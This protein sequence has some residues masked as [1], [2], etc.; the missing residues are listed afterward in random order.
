[1]LAAFHFIC[2]EGRQD[3]CASVTMLGAALRIPAEALPLFA[4]K[5]VR[6]FGHDDSAKL[7]AGARAVERWNAQLTS[8]GA[9]VDAFSFAGLQKPD[10]TPAKDLND[11]IEACAGAFEPGGKLWRI[12]S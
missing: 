7:H 8:A 6:I 9:I 12:L 5:Q 2:R 4:G 3:E 11:C 10:G 1:M